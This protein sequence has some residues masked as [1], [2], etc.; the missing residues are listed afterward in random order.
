MEE[1]REESQTIKITGPAIH[2]HALQCDY[3]AAESQDGLLCRDYNA[4]ERHDRLHQCDRSGAERRGGLLQRDRNVAGCHESLLW[5]G[6]NVVECHDGLHRDRKAVE[7]HDSLLRC[8]YNV[9]AWHDALHGSFDCLPEPTHHVNTVHHG[10]QQ[11]L[12][13]ATD[14]SMLASS[15]YKQ[16]LYLHNTNFTIILTIHGR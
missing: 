6:R 1:K 8:S 16:K 15:L 4:V 14:H 11:T 2:D 12:Y 7:R 3:S 13:T 10:S 9:A 5:H